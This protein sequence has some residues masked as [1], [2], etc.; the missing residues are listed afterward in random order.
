MPDD[1]DRH[2]ALHNLLDDD[3]LD[4]GHLGWVRVRVGVGVG[5]RV[6][7]GVGLGLGLGLG[8]TVWVGV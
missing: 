2:L 8:F 5:V 6:R 1:L 7:V 4:D 3:F